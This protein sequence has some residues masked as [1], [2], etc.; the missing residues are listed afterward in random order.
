MEKTNYGSKKISHVIMIII[1]YLSLILAAIIVIAPVLVI[2]FAAFKTRSEFNVSGKLDL[3]NSFLYFDNFKTAFTDGGM[4]T[5]LKNTL[6]LMGMSLLGT[7]LFGAMVAYVLSRFEFFGKKLIFGAYLVA[8]LIPMVTTQVATYKIVSFLGLVGTIWA[9]IALYL[10]ADVMSLYIM[11]LFMESIHVSLDE[12]A[13]LDGASYPFIFFRIIL[14]N[15]KPAIATVAIIRG[16][17]IYNDFYIPF[18]YMP[19]E[20]LQTL[21]TSLYKFMG[22]YGGQWNVICAG[23]ILII[24]PTLVAFLSMQKYIYNGFV[25]GSVK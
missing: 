13:K 2:L 20:K 24:I 9:P 14:P 19:D 6:F 23:V 22:P 10:G 16:V 15:L 5:G 25:A 17:T 1:K 21:S 3:P 11:L 18:L 12:S 4:I 7:I 8:M